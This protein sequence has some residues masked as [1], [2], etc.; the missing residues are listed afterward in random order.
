MKII[1]KDI[2]VF[3]YDDYLGLGNVNKSCYI[4]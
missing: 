2:K 1:Q 4:L 3:I